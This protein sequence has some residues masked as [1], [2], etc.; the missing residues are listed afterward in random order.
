MKQLKRWRLALIPIV[1]GIVFP[2]F[3]GLLGFLTGGYW[4]MFT[5]MMALIG[6]PCLAMGVFLL[7]GWFP[8]FEGQAA[9]VLYYG[10]MFVGY[11]LSKMMHAHPR[12]PYELAFVFALAVTLAWYFARKASKK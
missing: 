5:M 10:T 7:L 1:G 6:Y 3:L 8:D 2:A 4:R 11:E 9:C 12:T